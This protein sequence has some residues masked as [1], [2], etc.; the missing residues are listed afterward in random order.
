MLGPGVPEGGPPDAG[1]MGRDPLLFPLQPALDEDGNVKFWDDGADDEQAEDKAFLETINDLQKQEDANRVSRSSIQSLERFVMIYIQKVEESPNWRKTGVFHPSEVT[2]RDA[3]ERFEVLVRKIPKAKPEIEEIDPDK[4]GF[5]SI[6][7]AIHKWWQNDVLGKARVLKGTWEC[8][9]CEATVRGFMP[10][11]PCKDCKWP[12]RPRTWAKIMKQM[13][14]P[15]LP[16]FDPRLA[17]RTICRWPN[18]YDDPKR[19]CAMCEWG[20]A[21]NFVEPE[22]EHPELEIF[23][24]CDG[25]LELDAE[26]YV[27]ELKSKSQFLFQ[28]LEAP[29]HEHVLQANAYMKILKV[30]KAL[31]P[32]VNKGNGRLKTFALEYDPALW[33]EI[34][35]FIERVN[36]GVKTGRL[37]EGICKTPRDPNAKAC[38]YREECFSGYETIGDITYSLEKQARN[39]AAL[40]ARRAKLGE[41]NRLD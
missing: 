34:E 5:F 14:K 28:N 17:C 25:I 1:E 23:G 36:K 33:E 3:C 37:P 12:K 4:F 29:D 40:A 8:T 7:K 19:D 38:P 13:N 21:W 27:L 31:I 41:S 11:H 39:R 9:R 6:G 16:V 24:H 10:N 22:V 30:K 2:A 35:V 18:G 15:R 26:D 32:Y 20:G